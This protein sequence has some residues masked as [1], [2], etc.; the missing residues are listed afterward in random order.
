MAVPVHWLL[1]LQPRQPASPRMTVW[2]P[3]CGS[4]CAHLAQ[5]AQSTRP[6]QEL[7]QQH[8]HHQQQQWWQ[9][10]VTAEP[11]AAAVEAVQQA[12]ELPSAEPLRVAQSLGHDSEAL[13][14]AAWDWL[15]MVHGW[16]F[17]HEPDQASDWA[18]D[19]ASAQ[20]GLG[21]AVL[22][23]RSLQPAVTIQV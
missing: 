9:A 3:C 6:V 10:L 5:C 20:D 8:H 22:V 16:A 14:P 7:Q 19:W 12:F 1:P 4:T 23:V 21:V 18:S 2:W 11:V 17:A 15:E 13:A